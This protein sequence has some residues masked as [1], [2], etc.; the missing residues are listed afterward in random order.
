MSTPNEDF[1]R[2]EGS[3]PDFRSEF[4]SHLASL[5]PEAIADGK[6]DIKKIQELLGDDSV[7]DRERF[8]LYW[9]GKKR[10]LRAA[11]DSTTATLKPDIEN[12][13]N[14]NETK[15]LF[16]EG[17]NLEVLKVLQKHYHGKIK[18]I[19]ID[20]P[21]N[22]GKDFIY[23]D[24]YKEGLESYLEWS[25]QVNEE[26]K[27]ISSNSE[28]EGRYHSNWLN[29]MY[30]RLKLARNLLRD[31][32][33]IFISIGD[34]E[35]HHLAKISDEI[36]GEANH[37]ATFAWK[38]RGTGGQVAKNAIIKQ[39]EYVLLYARSLDG[40]QLSGPKNENE[41]EEGWR[42]FRKSGGQWQRKHR[43]NQYYPFY[44]LKDGSLS[45]NETKGATV[46][47]P[48]DSNGV[49]GFWENGMETARQRIEQGD[50]R[51]K[52]AKQGLKIEQR[53]VAKATSNAGSFIDIPSTRG[54][55]EIKKYFGDNVVFENPK[56][57][58]VLKA[59]AV[60]S[61]V[62]DGEIVLDF[63]AGSGSTAD[64]I[65]RMN[66]EDGVSRQWILV[67]LPEPVEEDT[68]A[69]ASGF[70][71]ISDLSR[72]RVDRAGDL[73][74]SDLLGGSVDVG[75]R[76]FSL[77]D[78]NFPK[79]KVDSDAQPNALEQHLLDLKQNS[80]SSTT[81]EALLFEILIKQGYSLSEKIEELRLDD[82]IVQN[83]GSGLVLALVEVQKK[84]TL[85]QLKNVLSQNPAR[86]IILEDI[87]EGDDE[88]KTNL[89]QECKSRGIELWT[90]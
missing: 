9:P 63:F 73:I 61:D 28:T 38:K 76:T 25:R 21:Y 33:V 2:T 88:L 34:T 20:P 10:A 44:L 17:D 78:T 66:S 24:N 1:Q 53:D 37:V 22:T 49:D 83:V 8:G 50:F 23:P 62:R 51:V 56:P 84:P 82:L 79:W 54:T 80:A 4:A 57:T 32:G 77:T 40:L 81:P 5:F 15:N 87:F 74:S 41:G 69:A 47:L 6:V 64:A 29:M 60:I 45:L 85:N 75:Y 18:M 90:A 39:V 30:P 71:R 72:A 31:D 67:Q 68:P 55:D 36:F 65:M 3:S 58:E 43:P 11:Q 52:E 14:W 26:G 48:Q 12:S 7:D 27:K 59:L 13:K 16:I 86:F 70:K 35:L 89:V 46:I 42:D 19:Y